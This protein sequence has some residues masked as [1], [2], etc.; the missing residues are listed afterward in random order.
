MIPL[1]C[2]KC[3]KRLSRKR[4]RMI[5]GKVLCSACLF[6]PRKRA[7]TFER[8]NFQ[9]RERT[10]YELVGSHNSTVRV[11]EEPWHQPGCAGCDSGSDRNGEDAGTAAECE[12]SQSGQSEAKASPTPLPGDS[13]HA[14]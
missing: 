8:L 2:S 11:G 3:N 7:V 13:D 4:A 6:A 12:A 10:T 1:F 9:T 14:Q 5:D